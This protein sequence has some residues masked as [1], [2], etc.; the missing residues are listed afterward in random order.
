MKPIGEVINGYIQELQK[1]QPLPGSQIIDAAPPQETLED[2]ITRIFKRR[3]LMERGFFLPGELD[4]E[5]IHKLAIFGQTNNHKWFVIKGPRGRGKTL[6]LESYRDALKE[7]H[8]NRIPNIVTADLIRKCAKY[9]DKYFR[10]NGDSCKGYELYQW[11]CSEFTYIAID[12]LGAEIPPEDRERIGEWSKDYGESLGPMAQLIRD[13][14]FYNL[15]TIFTTNE[16]PA[17]FAK[18]YGQKE[19]SRLT[20]WDYVLYHKLKGPDLRHIKRP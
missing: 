18:H 8:F 5:L 14:R 10:F 9:E 13:R 1:K 12:D 20:Q 4:K 16:D 19:A 2:A 11:L 6:L 7:M 17:F 15:R 3:V